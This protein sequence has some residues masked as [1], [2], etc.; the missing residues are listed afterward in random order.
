MSKAFD[1]SQLL[2]GVPAPID[3]DTV[4]GKQYSQIVGIGFKN[5]VINGDFA[6]NQRALAGYS[7][8]SDEVNLAS[9]GGYTLDRMYT[10][11]NNAGG[12]F[13]VSQ[14]EMLPGIKSW[15]ATVDTAVVDLTWD[16]TIYRYWY[17][18]KYSFEGMHLYDLVANGDSITIS[19][20]FNS[21]VSGTY[22]VVMR[23]LT[24]TN[25]G[26]DSYVTEF[27]YTSGAPQKVTV[28]VPLSNTWSAAPADT[29]TLGFDL[30]IGFIGDA[31]VTSALN[32]WQAGN[33]VCSANYTNWGATAGNFIEVAQLQVEKGPRATD[34]EYIPFDVQL[35]R[36]KRYYEKSYAYPLAPGYLTYYGAAYIYMA[37]I[38]YYMGATVSFSV[39][40]RANPSLITYSPDS[41]AAGV[42]FLNGGT[43]GAVDAAPYTVR[44]APDTM[45][46]LR[47]NG[48]GYTS[49]TMHYHWVAEA[50]F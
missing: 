4:D 49:T 26:I 1:N 6:V 29:S 19:F 17:G 43:G 39:T 9:E 2:N 31:H 37:E 3:A 14:G 20:L 21:N 16:G 36:C 47:Q 22:S 46:V 30:V 38:D 13:T 34:F 28:S 15:K 27:S 32:Q 33:F 50:E 18:L 10:R 35:S 7:F 25:I 44:T 5:R 11:N 24:D 41:G 23:N 12:Q 48:L 42:V 40:K 45:F 8:A